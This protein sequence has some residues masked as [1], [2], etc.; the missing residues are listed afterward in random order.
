MCY[1]KTSRRLSSQTNLGKQIIVMNP[2]SPNKTDKF[3][4]VHTII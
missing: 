1:N 4:I 3:D 2:Q